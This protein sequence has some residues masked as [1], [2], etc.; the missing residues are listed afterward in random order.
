MHPDPCKEYEH[1]AIAIRRPTT[2]TRDEEGTA[3][4]LTSGRGVLRKFRVLDFRIK[5][6]G[7]LGFP[8]SQLIN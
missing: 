2:V 8:A 6:I 4:A 5:D 7:R 1:G 3:F